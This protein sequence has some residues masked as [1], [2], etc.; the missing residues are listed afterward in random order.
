MPAENIGNNTPSGACR[1]SLEISLAALI[2][3]TILPLLLLSQSLVTWLSVV[4]A[5]VVTLYFFIILRTARRNSHIRAPPLF[6]FILFILPFIFAFVFWVEAY[7]LTRSISVSVMA[8]GLIFTFWTNFFAVPLAIY[9]K[10][11]E[12]MEPPLRDSPLVSIIVPAFNEERVIARSIESLVETD[13]PNKEII[14]VDD[15]STDNTFAIA[16]SYGRLGVKVYRKE[17]GGKHSALNYGIR[18]SSGEIIVTVD[19]DSIIARGAVRALVRKFQDDAVNAVCGNIKVLNRVNWV[20]RCQALEYVA[21]INIFRRAFDLFG[22]VAVVP[23]A[24]GAYRRSVLE[25]GGFYDPDTI[26]EDFD[27][28]IKTLKSGKIVQASS[29]AIAYTEAPV[30][31]G[32][33]Y[34]QRM[35]WYRGNFQTIRKHRDAFLNSRYGFLYQLTLPFVLLTMAVL[36][37]AGVAVWISAALSILSGYAAHVLLMLS[38][39]L[40]LQFLLSLLA[41]EIDGED[42]RLAFYS[43]FFVV[44]YKHLID[45][46]L[47]KALFDV[48]IK[49]EFSWTRVRR[50]G[51]AAE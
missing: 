16:S 33:L 7:E 39:F 43:P 46:F 1:G 29:D 15:G 10:R 44:G 25:E 4:L 28:T 11:L 48:L 45:F 3:L 23:G 37:F 51:E 34:R 14:V 8:L 22:A 47:I 30:S 27:T 41:I 20:T 32:D 6:V 50:I 18:L 17:N 19:A 5:L 9:H 49:K 40:A 12:R 36:P 38:I 24:L 42:R 31:L 26:V 21:G 35:R 2:F 13:Y